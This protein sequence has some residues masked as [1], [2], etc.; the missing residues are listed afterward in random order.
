MLKSPILLYTSKFLLFAGFYDDDIGED[1]PYYDPESH[2]PLTSY[3][4]FKKR[5]MKEFGKD[6]DEED[7]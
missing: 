6:S 7:T 3:D 4:A 5:I 2:M 1:H